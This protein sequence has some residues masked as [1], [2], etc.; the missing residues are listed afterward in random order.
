MPDPEGLAELGRTG[1]VT[2]T[3]TMPTSAVRPFHVWLGVVLH[4]K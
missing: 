4:R 3:V 2:T 1:P